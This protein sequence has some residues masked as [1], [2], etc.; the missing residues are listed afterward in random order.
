MP[1][2]NPFFSSMKIIFNVN[3]T[4]SAPDPL[5][6]RLSSIPYFLVL[7]FVS[8]FLCHHFCILHF[9]CPC[10]CREPIWNVIH[11]EVSSIIRQFCLRR[12]SSRQINNILLLQWCLVFCDLLQFFAFCFPN[13]KLA[14]NLMHMFDL[15]I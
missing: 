1:M 11:F 3:K 5:L 2:R 7:I 9:G 13:N 6:A 8:L 15:F 14:I 12:H 10:A 4:L